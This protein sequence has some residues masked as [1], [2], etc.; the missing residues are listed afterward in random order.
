MA[1]EHQAS[2]ALEIQQSL[3]EQYLMHTYK[4]QPVEFVAGK[5]M[6]L[7]DSEGKEYLDFLGGIASASLGHSHPAVVKAIQEQAGKV[8]QTS[9]YFYAEGRGEL[10]EKISGLIAGDSGKTFKSFFC[11]SGAEANEGAFK[12]ARRYAA[13]RGSDA[14]TILY[15]SS[16]FHG[17]TLATIAAT[18]QP[19]KQ[20]IFK[21]LPEGFRQVPQNDVEALEKAMESGDV[22]GV[23]IECIQG[24]SGIWPCSQGFVEAVR[25]LTAAHGAVMIVDE[26]QTGFFRTGMP[27]GFMNYGVLP[28]V[29][30]MA[31]G[32]GGGFPMGAF[33]AVSEVADA[34][35]PGDHGTTFGGNHLAIAAANAA[36][37][38]MVALDVGR[39]VNEV[40]EYLCAKLALMPMA[41][42]VRGMGL[43]V[44]LQIDRPVAHEAIAICRERGLVVNA[45]KDDVLRFVPPLICSKD[46]VRAMIAILEPV[47]EELAA[48]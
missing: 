46:D 17:R 42:E 36:I 25:D 10:A 22:C 18:G 26:V 44:G 34:F 45:P 7:V 35:Q 20:D 9:N 16:S 1:T 23:I 39:N 15:L 14:R 19:S 41:V 3:E 11:N 40:G 21:P 48:R 6:R 28:D 33:A 5:G 43:M 27:F 4:R 8:I 13:S 38:T 31:K 29:V 2:S 12:V 32:I 47:L 37:D 30:T 24:E